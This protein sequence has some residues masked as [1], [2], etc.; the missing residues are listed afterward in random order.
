MAEKDEPQWVRDNRSDQAWAREVE[1]MDKQ[2]Q[3]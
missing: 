3:E 1:E 2:S